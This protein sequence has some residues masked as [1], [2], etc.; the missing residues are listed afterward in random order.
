MLIIRWH[1]SSV[2][3]LET[4]IISALNSI[5]V[6][7]FFFFEKPFP[8]GIHKG[9]SHM[10]LNEDLLGASSVHMWNGVEIG[11]RWHASRKCHLESPKQHSLCA[12][13]LH[14]AWTTKF[15]MA[16][17]WQEDEA[18]QYCTTCLNSAHCSLCLQS[19]LALTGHDFEIGTHTV[20]LGAWCTFSD[21]QNLAFRLLTSP[22][23][24]KCASSENQIL[25]NDTS[26]FWA[27][28]PNV[29]LWCLFWSLS[30]GNTVL[31]CGYKF[32]SLFNIRC[33]D[34]LG[35]PRC[36]ATF[37]VDLLGLLCSDTLTASM[38]SGERTGERRR[39]FLSSIEPSLLKWL[40]SLWIVSNEGAHLVSKLAQKHLC[41]TTTLVVSLKSN[42]CF[43]ALFYKQSFFVSHRV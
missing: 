6:C 28:S 21:D 4:W 39:G 34:R 29:I 22:F 32:K 1:M 35:V 25:L 10:G 24:W 26:L 31:L 19:K 2:I 5:I 12:A 17:L 30:L 16:N 27:H 38:L 9:S 37:L 41:V 8:Q 11:L 13:W 3:S 18:Q 20:I 36:A 42:T 23:N 15:V 40:S 14:P 33:T 7:S 43:Y